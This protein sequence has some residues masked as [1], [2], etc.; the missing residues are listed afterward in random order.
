MNTAV[1]SDAAYAIGD[2]TWARGAP[3]FADAIAQAHEHHLR[4]HC[5]CQPGGPGIDMYVARVLNGYNVK[6]MPN[7][8][9]QHATSCPS[10]EPPAEFSGLGQLVG[11]AIVENPATG[12]TALKLDFAMTKLPGRTTLPAAAGNSS[13]VASQGPKL[14]LRALLHYL[15]DQAE[16][17][18]WKTG[19]AG[20]RT[21]GTVRK[22][23][24]QAAENKF[25]HG[26]ALLAS[27]Y[28]PEVFSVEQCEAITARRLRQWAH[29]RPKPGQPQPL[30]LLV[31]EVKEIVPSRYGHKA[32]LKHIPDQ[33]FALDEALYRRLGRCFEQELAAWG[34]DG[35]LHLLMIA[36]FR[37]DDAGVPSL[38]ELSL[39][40]A[41][42]QWLP[43]EDGWE[44]QLVGALVRNGR[45]FIKGLR[46]NEAPN[47]P[48]VAASL[49]DCGEAPRPLLITRDRG[50]SDLIPPDFMAQ[51]TRGD[52]PLWRWNPTDGDMPTLPP[53]RHCQPATALP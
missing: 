37:V 21:W 30:M 2:H 33:A 5:L 3:G 17:T 40:L 28:I 12:E 46:Y 14:G 13:S 51:T 8:G 1:A 20:R 38:V 43:V 15:W 4:P 32:I 9:S 23:L 31:A 35:D 29:A 41:T 6:R 19:F 7:T 36:T 26:H 22:H 52:T 11:T 16:L 10:Y 27:L 18:H 48:L 39:M 50:Q 34:T 45:C 49:L 42:A 25:T 24:L 47:Q 53:K 44:K